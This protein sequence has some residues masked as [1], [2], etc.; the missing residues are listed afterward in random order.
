MSD[1]MEPNNKKLT[2]NSN[3]ITPK[4]IKLLLPG[5]DD[6]SSISWHYN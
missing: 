5:I 2:I 6:S 3:V 4:Q 1:K